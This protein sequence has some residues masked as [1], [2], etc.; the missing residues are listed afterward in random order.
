M[1]VACQPY[2]PAAFTP[3]K[4]S[5]YSFL[6]EAIVRSEGFYMN[7][8]STD[9]S[10][11]FVAQHLNHCATAVPPM[12]WQVYFYIYIYILGNWLG[13]LGWHKGKVNFTPEQATKTQRGSRVYL[14]SFL[15]LGAG[16]CMWSTP[17]RGCFTPRKK[18]PYP[19]YRRLGGAPGPVWMGAENLVPHRDLI[20]GPSIP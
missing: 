9:T 18:T 5:W 11:R 19:F 4:Y 14:Y 13:D 2:A 16:W 8:K 1:V 12:W 20:R 6:L 7:E 10:F 17:R 3:R 15:N